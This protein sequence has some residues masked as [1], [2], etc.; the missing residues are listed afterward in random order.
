MD[1]KDNLIVHWPNK[2]KKKKQDYARVN[3]NIYL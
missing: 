1:R 3:E 2:K